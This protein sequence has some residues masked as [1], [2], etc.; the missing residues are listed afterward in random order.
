MTEENPKQAKYH[1]SKLYIERLDKLCQ[2]LN[3]ITINRETCHPK[4]KIEICKNN[5]SLLLAFYKELNSEMTPP[6]QEK[7]EKAYN[8]VKSNF[9]KAVKDFENKGKCDIDFISSFD[10]WE[11][12]LRQFQSDKGLLMPEIDEGFAEDDI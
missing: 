7:H 12:E 5:F 6:L 3:L 11:R 8:M 1:G 9:F 4:Q 2:S 10:Y